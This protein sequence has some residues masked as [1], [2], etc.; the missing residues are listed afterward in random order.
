MVQGQRLVE[1]LFHQEYGE[2]GTH[3]LKAQCNFFAFFLACVSDDREMR[4]VDFEPRGR[5]SFASR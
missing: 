4:G 2:D 3:L 5:L 1:A